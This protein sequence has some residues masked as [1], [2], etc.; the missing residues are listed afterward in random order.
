MTGLREIGFYRDVIGVPLRFV[1]DVDAEHARLQ[2]AGA[3]MLAPPT[4]RA[5]G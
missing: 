5:V 4:D 2:P 1:D 3:R